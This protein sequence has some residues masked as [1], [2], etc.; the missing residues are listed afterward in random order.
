MLLSRLSNLWGKKNVHSVLFFLLWLTKHLNRKMLWSSSS[1]RG[2]VR[3]FSL[4]VTCYIWPVPRSQF[5]GEGLESSIPALG[6]CS[7]WITLESCIILVPIT[8][9]GNRQPETARSRG[10]AGSLDGRA[11]ARKRLVLVTGSFFSTFLRLK[12]KERFK[13][14]EERKRNQTN[15]PGRGPKMGAWYS[16]ILEGGGIWGGT[17]QPRGLCSDGRW[18]WWGVNSQR[19]VCVC[20]CVCVLCVCVCVCVCCGVPV[21]NTAFKGG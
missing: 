3:T 17:W 6:L 16:L 10:R 11:T 15:M 8:Y 12:G 20:V 14:R 19:W 9:K 7:T 21:G 18:A 5:Y 4:K 2:S 1:P 13:K